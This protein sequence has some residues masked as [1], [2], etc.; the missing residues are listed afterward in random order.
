MGLITTMLDL[1]ASTAAAPGQPITPMLAA[2]GGAAAGPGCGMPGMP[3]DGDG[4]APSE[5]PASE[6]PEDTPFFGVPG[7]DLVSVR[8]LKRAGD[9]YKSERTIGNALALMVVLPLAAPL[10][11]L[12]DIVRNPVPGNQ[13]PNDR[14]AHG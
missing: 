8:I 12:E 13:T 10:V 6:A 7:N 9:R 1:V 3:P 11:V 14:C 4:G 5:D 2:G